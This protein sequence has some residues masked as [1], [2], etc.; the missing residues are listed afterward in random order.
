MNEIKCPKCN[1]VFKVDEA[2]F[3][4]IIKQVRNHEFENEL[5]DRLELSEKEK[6]VAIE[7]AEANLKNSLQLEVTKK[8]SELAEIK[9]QIKNAE[10]LKKLAVTE[11]VNIVEKER[12]GLSAKLQSTSIRILMVIG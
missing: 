3:A 9:S 2:G 11:A 10:I 4:D 8:E 5:R 1:E 12:D 7:L 6:Q